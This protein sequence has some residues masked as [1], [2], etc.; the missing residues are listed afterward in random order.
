MDT[1]NNLSTIEEII[2]HNLKLYKSDNSHNK[3]YINKLK[4]YIYPESTVDSLKDTYYH[5]VDLSQFF[6]NS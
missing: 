6:G 3:F 1:L 2:A 5:N 4:I